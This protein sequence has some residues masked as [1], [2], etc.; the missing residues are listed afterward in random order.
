MPA[1]TGAAG[2][3]G[4]QENPQQQQQPGDLGCSEEVTVALVLTRPVQQPPTVAEGGGPQV[5]NYKAFRRR[6]ERQLGGQQQ[7]QGVLAVELVAAEAPHLA[8][9][10]IDTFLRCVSGVCVLGRGGGRAKCGGSR[11]GLLKMQCHKRP[12]VF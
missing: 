10:D 1:G 6:G 7:Q 9:P 3:A 12:G 11:S 8:G 2:D 4:V 5:P